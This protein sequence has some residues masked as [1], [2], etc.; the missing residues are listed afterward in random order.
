[1]ARVGQSDYHAG[2]LAGELFAKEGA[3]HVLCV[4]HAP[5]AVFAEQRCSGLADSLKK[6]G[7]DSSALNI[8]WADATN[9]GKV[10]QAIQGALSSDPKIDGIFTLGSSVAMDA[11]RAATQ[12]GVAE[13]VKIGSVD[14]SSA[15]L[16]AIQDGK[17]LF[18]I[19]Q[20]PYLQG[21]YA[22]AILAQNARYGM[23]LVGQVA[24]GPLAI[25]KA[26]VDRVLKVNSEHHGI[27]GAL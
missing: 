14:L 18:A 17:I 2:F 25:D 20:Q 27:R 12:Q 22:V 4:N 26:N 13:K 1:M 21:Y 3:H 15:V 23:H 16:N 11:V 5:G 19:D 6:A 8:P 7:G 10:T 9:P 24:T